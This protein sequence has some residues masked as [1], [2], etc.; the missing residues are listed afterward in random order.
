MARIPFCGSWRAWSPLSVLLLAGGCISPAANVRLF[1]W[2]RGI[3]V[4]SLD[5]PGM[6][7]YLWFYEW[8]MF[9]AVQSGQH[10]HADFAQF[11]HHVDTGGKRAEIRGV[12]TSLKIVA[13]GDGAEMRLRIT[14][15]SDHDW[16]ETAGI[17][18]CFNPGPTESRNPLFANRNTWFVGPDGLAR[19]D[20]REIHFNADLR[21][22]VNAC[23]DHGQFVWSKKWPTSPVNAAAGLLLRESSDGK[24]TAGIA[25]ER[26]L[27]AQGHNPWECMH[28]CVLVGPLKKGES[29]TIRGR[30]YLFQGTRDDC[31]ARYRRDFGG[32][33]T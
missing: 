5:Q 33:G 11:S 1:E 6:S 15:R 14:N 13:A 18:P 24:W 19:Q 31:L 27:S 29:R 28:L 16:P 7:M 25:W 9:D 2:E 30:I 32:G 26:F 12:D 4:E 8:N 22:R 10:T 23:S 20:Q 21:G 3:G 17:I